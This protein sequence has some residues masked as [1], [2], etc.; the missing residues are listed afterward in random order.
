M[1]LL[2]L[3]KKSENIKNLMKNNFNARAVSEELKQYDDLLKLFSGVQ[4]EYHR[5]LDNDQKK[6]DDVWL[7]EVDQ[8]VFTFKHS[9]H[10]YLQENREV[11]SRRSGSSR[12]TK[13]QAQ[14]LV[15]SL[16]SMENQLRSKLLMKK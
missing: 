4:G 12:K 16:E 14:V 15:L 3:Q 7:D 9:V 1:L 6:A 13:S 2:R 10:N 8:K 11:L 5:K